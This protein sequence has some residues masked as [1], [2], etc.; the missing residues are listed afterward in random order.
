[1]TATMAISIG[2]G[3]ITGPVIGGLLYQNFGYEA[4]FLLTFMISF[5]PVIFTKILVPEE[6][7]E[8]DEI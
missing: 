6:A 2:A 5:L 8:E 7:D 1:M 4:P 3:L